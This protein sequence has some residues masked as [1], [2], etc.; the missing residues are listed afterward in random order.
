MLVR[1]GQRWS[2]GLRRYI[3]VRSCRTRVMGFGVASLCEVTPAKDIVGGA[4][5]LVQMLAG[6]VL[7]ESHFLCIRRIFATTRGLESMQNRRSTLYT[8]RVR[9]LTRHEA[10]YP[11]IVTSYTDW[12]RALTALCPRF[13]CVCVCL[14]VGPCFSLSRGR[15]FSRHGAVHREHLP[16]PLDEERQP[17]AV[18]AIA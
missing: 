13:V 9:G 1:H 16:H 12:R 2:V 11:Y 17:G 3:T 15:C 8:V 4:R 14:W 18:S 5:R 10:R 6:R 7:L